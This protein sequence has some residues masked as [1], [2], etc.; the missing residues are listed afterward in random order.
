MFKETMLTESQ[1]H[2]AVGSSS[3]K[4]EI[5]MSPSILLYCYIEKL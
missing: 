5:S 1:N 3:L 2:E 4:S